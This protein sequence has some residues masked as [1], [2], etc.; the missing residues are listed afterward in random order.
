MGW[1]GTLAIRS[2]LRRH[3]DL[4]VSSS[5][6]GA[7]RRAGTRRH[8]PRDDVASLCHEAL[9]LDRSTAHRTTFEC[10]AT[11]TH[12][13]AMDWNALAPDPPG[14]LPEVDHVMAMG[15]ALGGALLLGAA[16]LR[17]VRV[18]GRHVARRVW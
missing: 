10:W 5:R 6:R 14:P 9:C 17:G 11:D 16:G 12:A 2:M 3:R 15:V 18:L 1:G 7:R 13:R 8:I 4:A